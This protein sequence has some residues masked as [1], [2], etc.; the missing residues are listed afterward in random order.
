MRVVVVRSQATVESVGCRCGTHVVVGA[1][2]HWLRGDGAVITSGQDA[3]SRRQGRA[4][5]SQDLGNHATL[6]KSDQK[7]SAFAD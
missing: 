6:A 2:C 1:A 5:E 3:R 7:E 4:M